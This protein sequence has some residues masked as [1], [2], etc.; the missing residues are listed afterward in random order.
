MAKAEGNPEGEVFIRI[1]FTV[2]IKG[3]EQF[4]E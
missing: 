4:V 2:P 3:R 1:L